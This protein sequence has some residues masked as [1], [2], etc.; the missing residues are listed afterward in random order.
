M[1]K[2]LAIL[3]IQIQNS[4]QYRGQLFYW[5]MNEALVLTMFFFVWRA[6]FVG[7]SRVRDYTFGAMVTYYLTA[8]LVEFLTSAYME[9]SME[10]I[11]KNGKLSKYII[12]PMSFFW[13]QVAGHIGWKVTR[14]I[15][16]LPVYFIILYLLRGYL[17]FPTGQQFILFLVALAFAAMLYFFISYLISYF[18]FWMLK[19][20][21]LVGILRGTLIP[22]LA[23]AL[24]PLDIFPPAVE[25]LTRF[26]PFRYMIFFPVKVFLGQV[27]EAE[28][29]TGIVV[30]LIWVGLMA[31]LAWFLWQPALRRYES[32]GG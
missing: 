15:V 30:G 8:F 20:S 13:Y 32:A 28:F 23:G 18:A 5:V 17:I 16:T 25:R 26:L 22:L 14:L 6:I 21:Y 10:D 11:V 24:I 4:F 3:N 31:T 12:R 29:Q 2:Y 1:K 19:I 9:Y 7:Q 27:T